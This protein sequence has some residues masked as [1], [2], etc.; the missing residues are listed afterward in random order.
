MRRNLRNAF[1]LFELL[2]V[3]ALLAVLTS[4]AVPSLQA[5]QSRIEV[6]R[7]NGAIV[8]MISEARRRAVREGDSW[9]IRIEKQPHS[10]TLMNH[11]AIYWQSTEDIGHDR[12]VL[13]KTIQIEFFKRRDEERLDSLIVNSQGKITPGRIWVSQNGRRVQGYE[14]DRLTG[15]IHRIK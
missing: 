13:S 8:E 6:D 5:W 14:I 15:G 4:V 11:S 3:L 7:A 12:R 1:S 9:V 2:L 10:L